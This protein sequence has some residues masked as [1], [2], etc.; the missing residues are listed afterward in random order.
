[1]V[2]KGIRFLNRFCLSSPQYNYQIVIDFIIS[3]SVNRGCGLLYETHRQIPFTRH[4]PDNLTHCPK[5][6]DIGSPACDWLG[7]SGFRGRENKETIMMKSRYK[8][9]I[10]PVLLAASVLAAQPVLADSKAEPVKTMDKID[11]A[12]AEVGNKIIARDA[13][14]KAVNKTRKSMSKEQNKA[15]HDIIAVLQSTRDSI[16]ALDKKDAKAAMEKLEKAIGKIEIVL[17]KNP[18]MKLVPF[19]ISSE[20]ID[21]ESDVK[22][23]DQVVKKAVKLLKDGRLQDARPLVASL[24]S[25]VVVQITNIPL[26]TYPQAIKLAVP[27]IEKGKLEEAKAVLIAALN[28]MIVEDHII[29]LPIVRTEHMLKRAETLAEK[30]K[31]NDA[32]NKELAALLKQSRKSLQYAEALG[33]GKAE[34]FKVF[35]KQIDEISNKTSNGKH[36]KGFFNLI[37]KSLSDLRADLF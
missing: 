6:N 30:A 24:A 3:G 26:A 34:D 33:Y 32:E 18:N 19:G 4:L 9:M 1:M 36:G 16:A 29:P 10:T 27:L 35:Y 25:E 7:V 15:A 17:A 37:K 12:T 22:T 20:V 23:I 31:R 28:T 11:K 8:T 13:A 21:V 5:S 2:G 14:R